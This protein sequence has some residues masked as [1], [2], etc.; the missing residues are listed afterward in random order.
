[1]EAY[2]IAVL[3]MSEEGIP[4]I[5]SA[6]SGLYSS[7]FLLK[8]SKPSVFSLTNFSLTK[9]SLMITFAIAF[10]SQTSVPGRS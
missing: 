5:F 9:P 6:S 3:I 4:V 7:T 8:I 1:M 2:S 10:N